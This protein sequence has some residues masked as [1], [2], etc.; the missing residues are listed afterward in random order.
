MPSSLE[1]GL[2]HAGGTETDHR[3]L[4]RYQVLVFSLALVWGLGDAVSTYAAAAATGSTAMEANPIIRTL[5]AIDPMLLA[6]FKAAVVVVVGVTLFEWRSLV[7]R[8]PGHRVWLVGCVG[9]GLLVTANNVAI[10]LSAL[11]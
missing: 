6:V 3:D 8:V 4:L 5:L 7:E 9:L 10:G 1:P 11:V 2:W